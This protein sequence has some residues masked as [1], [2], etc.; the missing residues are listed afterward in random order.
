MRCLQRLRFGLDLT[1][2][3]VLTTTQVGTDLDCFPAFASRFFFEV[4][5]TLA[6]LDSPDADVSLLFLERGEHLLDLFVIQGALEPSSL[7]ELN[8]VFLDR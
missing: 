1:F 8:H 6:I 2:L 5:F 7:D 4:S 3:L